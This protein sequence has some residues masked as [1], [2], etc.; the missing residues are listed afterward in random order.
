MAILNSLIIKGGR[1]QIGGMVLYSR[2]GNT[3]AR[4]LAASVTNPRTPA[5]ME[6]RVKLSNLVAVYRANSS[7]MRGAFEGKKARESDYNAFVSANVDNNA[8]AL[9]KSDVASG[10]AVVGPYKITSG[11][12]PV[13]E[14]TLNGSN[15]TTNIYVGTLS[16]ESTT[17]VGALSTAILA[18]NGGLEA[19]MQLSV[20]INLQLASAG[21]GV[22]Y[23]TTRAYEMILDV[24]SDVL[25]TDVI[26]GGILTTVGTTNKAL[27]LDT[28]TLGDGA[29][30]FILS[31]TTGGTTRVSSQSLV[32]FGSNATYRAYTS[33]TARNAAIA[34]YGEGTDT[35]L[36]S[37][38]ASGAQSV[39]TTL[40]L[41]GLDVDGHEVVSGGSLRSEFQ[42]N[43][44]VKF[45]FN[46]TLPTGA[47]VSAYYRLGNSATKYNLTNVSVEPGNRIVSGLVGSTTLP[48]SG[49]AMTFVAII[50]GDEYPIS[51]RAQSDNED[52][53][54]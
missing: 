14:T 53:M 13:I 38:S 46:R 37:N 1:K 48:S 32:F 7:W 25:V 26:P 41:L 24:D 40:A 50:D 43:T 49:Q 36:S 16:M 6:Q 42:A 23:I 31:H 9:S 51:V 3:I 28:S 27:G 45:L 29:A 12:L 17:T 18:N 39:E 11:S 4:E 21:T 47:V 35:F 54:E 44:E 5:Q 10:A 52:G 15:L 2:G 8:V 34:S 20:I 30:A 33:T 19:G 22:P